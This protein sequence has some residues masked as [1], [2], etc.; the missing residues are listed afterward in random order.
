MRHMPK[1]V[2]VMLWLTTICHSSTLPLLSY[3]PDC[4][5][6]QS[7]QSVPKNITSIKHSCNCRATVM[8][9]S[10]KPPTQQRC[11]CLTQT[12]FAASSSTDTDTTFQVKLVTVTLMPVWPTVLT[13]TFLWL[14]DHRTATSFHFDHIL[15]HKSTCTS[16]QVNV[17][18]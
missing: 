14:C 12:H 2:V 5:F 4:A 13:I 1:P 6:W 11:G 8:E 9:I 3:I 15:S 16:F 17:T 10:S 7:K 18:L